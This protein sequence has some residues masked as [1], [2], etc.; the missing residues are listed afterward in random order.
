M[1]SVRHQLAYVG[2]HHLIR[3]IM[4]STELDHLHMISV[5]RE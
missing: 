4:S 2:V 1:L 3:F 5:N